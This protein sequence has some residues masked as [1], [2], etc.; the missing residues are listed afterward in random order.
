MIDPRL[1]DTMLEVIPRTAMF[2][3]I[4]KKKDG[5]VR[6]MNCQRGVTKY[7]KGKESTTDHLPNL[8]TVHENGNGY[9]CFDKNRVLE[10]RGAGIICREA[11]K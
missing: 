9:R 8:V 5:S 3:V 6:K 2:T 1:V 7:L 10:I 11:N 4:F